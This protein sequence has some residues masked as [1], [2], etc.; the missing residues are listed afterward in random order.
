MEEARYP[1]HYGQDARA[2][3]EPRS[4]KPPPLLHRRAE[5]DLS[6]HGSRSGRYFSPRPHSARTMV[7]RRRHAPDRYVSHHDAQRRPVRYSRTGRSPRSVLSDRKTWPVLSRHRP[8]A[9]RCCARPPERGTVRR[10]WWRSGGISPD[11]QGPSPSCRRKAMFHAAAPRWLFERKQWRADQC[12]PRRADREDPAVAE[13]IR[14]K[15]RGQ[16]F[17]S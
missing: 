15:V 5:S 17:R 13:R 8:R 12:S 9:G 3:S 1:A 10:R 14:M 2:H 7:R 6:R 11:D 4:K 16:R